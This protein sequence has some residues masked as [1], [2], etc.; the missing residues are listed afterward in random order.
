MN[1]YDRLD[2]AWAFNQSLLCIGLD[3]RPEDVAQQYSGSTQPYVD[4]CIDIIEQ[5]HEYVCGYKMQIAFFS[6]QRQEAALETVIKHLKTKHPELVVVLDAKRGDIADT[7]EAYADEAFSRFNADAVTLNPYLG[8]DSVEPFLK[9][10]DRGSVFLCK[11][12]NRGAQDFQD[13]IVNGS[14]SKPLF[15]YIA[16][17]I[18]NEWNNRNCLLVIGATW[19]QA[20]ATVRSAHDHI[21]FLVPG[22]GSQG[23]VLHDVINAGL[24]S[25]GTGLIICASRS[26]VKKNSPKEAARLLMNEI[27]VCVRIR[28]RQC[29]DS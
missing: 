17:S 3:P 9:R 25:E 11:T 16:D 24:N 21:P 19:P 27:N 29:Y 28:R 20:I 2:Q 22:I 8:R 23:G 12:S 4:Y 26:I 10:A 13:I 7:A 1:F 18:A 14:T 5:T 15:E 6:S